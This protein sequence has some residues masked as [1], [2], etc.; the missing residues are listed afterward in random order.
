M[1]IFGE[2]LSTM[3]I[4]INFITVYDTLR[5]IRTSQKVE[6]TPHHTLKDAPAMDIWFMPGGKV[7]EHW[8]HVHSWKGY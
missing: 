7:T 4:E 3:N 8:Q 5:P 6:I 2:D 1:R